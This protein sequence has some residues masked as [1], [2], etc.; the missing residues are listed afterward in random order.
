MEDSWAPLDDVEIGL[1]PGTDLCDQAF[2]DDFVPVEPI[3][4]ATSRKRKSTV[5]VCNPRLRQKIL[6]N[7]CYRNARMLSGATI[8]VTRILTKC[9]DG[10]E[11]VTCAPKSFVRIAS[12]IMLSHPECLNSAVVT[13]LFPTSFAWLAV[14][15]GIKLTRFMA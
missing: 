13:V 6:T 5:S 2:E 8:T 12:H 1:D 11:G 14:F 4:T 3:P 7:T 10:K 9:C 15:D